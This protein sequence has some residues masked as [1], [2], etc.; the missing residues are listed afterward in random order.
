MIETIIEALSYH[1]RLQAEV[2]KEKIMKEIVDEKNNKIIGNVNLDNSKV[3]FIGSNNVLYINDEITLVNSS[4]EFRGDNSLVYL[5]KTSEKITVDI[6]LYNNSTIYFGKNIWINKGVKIVI[7]EQTNLFIGKNCMIAPECCFRSADP[8]IIYDINTKKRIN[9]SKS[10]F[11]GDH[12]WIGQG[13]MVLKNAMVGSGAVIGAKSLITNKRYNS[14][15]IYGGSPA[16]KIKEGIFFIHDDCHRFLDE[17]IEK[18]EY[19]DTDKYIYNRD[20]TTTEFED[21]DNNLRGASIKDRI[22]YL[23]KITLNNDK[24]R[25]YIGDQIINDGVVFGGSAGAIIF[26]KDIDICKYEGDNSIIGLKDTSGFD[27]LSG[28]S[29]LCH[30]NDNIVKTEN[31]INYLKEYSIGRK[32]IYLPEEDTIFIDSNDIELIG[33]KEY[34]VFNNGNMQVI[35]VTE[36][37]R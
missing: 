16:K 36:N 13:I 11:I 4:I 22:D 31:N 9:Q 6:K 19:N 33:D 24:N 20:G 35:T 8:H 27:V 29:L 30:Y 5:C 23:D 34:I 26:G 15:T 2:E 37:N 1:G 7:S 25:F 18:Y 14:N 17:D 21:I 12:V 32:V 10:I 3:K 28:Y